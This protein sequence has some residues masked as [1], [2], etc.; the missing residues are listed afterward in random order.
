MHDEFLETKITASIKVRFFI[1]CLRGNKQVTR[2]YQW[3]PQCNTVCRKISDMHLI[4]RY[5][6]WS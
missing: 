3:L 5:S 6:A 4:E 2:T 1:V